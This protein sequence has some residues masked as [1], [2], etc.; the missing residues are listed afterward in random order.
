MDGT[1]HAT[2]GTV[3]VAIQI[4]M[5]VTNALISVAETM[6]TTKTLVE[7]NT[8]GAVVGKEAGIKEDNKVAVVDKAETVL[9]IPVNMIGINALV[10][11]KVLI[12][13]PT[14]VYKRR[15]RA[16]EDKEDEMPISM[17]LAGAIEMEQDKTNVTKGVAM[18]KG[19]VMGTTMMGRF[20]GLNN[21]MLTALIGDQ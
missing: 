21:W 19:A 12:I 15:D 5:G 9:F 3:V 10:T 14:F 17:I 16:G 18:A 1:L 4:A 11:L 13:V 8:K 6:T 7:D 2:R 20:I